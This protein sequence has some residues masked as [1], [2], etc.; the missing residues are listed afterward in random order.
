MGVAGVLC[1]IEQ[2]YI[3][4]VLVQLAVCGTFLE[5]LARLHCLNHLVL[6][7]GEGEDALDV[8][9]LEDNPVL[10]DVVVYSRVAFVSGLRA[11]VPTKH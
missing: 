6:R 5:E 3:V 7:I 4:L 8:G 1:D 9:P 10:L 2:V 11:I